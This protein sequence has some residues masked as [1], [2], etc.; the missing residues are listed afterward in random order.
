MTIGGGRT[1]KRP[2]KPESAAAAIAASQMTTPAPARIVRCW[3][4]AGSSPSPVR[5]VAAT[6]SA[7][8]AVRP[9]LAVAGPL[10]AFQAWLFKGIAGSELQRDGELTIDGDAAVWRA[11]QGAFRPNDWKGARPAA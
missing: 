8:R 6:N 1:S 7:L 4:A 3:R 5:Q 9:Q 11:V 2:S 10:D